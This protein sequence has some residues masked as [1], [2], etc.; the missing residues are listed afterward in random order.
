M[1]GFTC[2]TAAARIHGRNQLD[3]GGVSHAMIGAC[4]DALTRFQRLAKGIQR[5][6]RKLREFIEKQYAMAGKRRLAGLRS[7]TTSDQ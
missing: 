2:H 3:A 5:L 1:A 4:D 6:R 7:K